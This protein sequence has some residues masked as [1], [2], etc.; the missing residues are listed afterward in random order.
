MM[1]YLSAIILSFLAVLGGF[2]ALRIKSTNDKLYAIGAKQFYDSVDS[3]LQTPRELPDG[4]LVLIADMNSTLNSKWS[5]F[6][7]Y[8]VLKEAN[9]RKRGERP[10]QGFDKKALRPEVE[11]L[12]NDA[13]AGWIT[14]MRYKSVLAGVGIEQQLRTARVKSGSISELPDRSAAIELYT[15]LNSRAAA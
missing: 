5:P 10:K 7:L 6:A 8:S 1:Y 12:M 14:A 2:V 9:K 13:F 15:Y 4:M 11:A 3:I